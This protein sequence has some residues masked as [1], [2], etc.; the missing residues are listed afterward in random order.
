MA[1]ERE[2]QRKIEAATVT[3]V[4]PGDAAQEKE[5]GY[6]CEPAD[7]PAGRTNGRSNR[8]GSGWFSY[9][10]TVDGNAKSALIV[11]YL[12]EL[13]LLPAAGSF[14]IQIEGVTIAKFESNQTAVGFWEATYPVPAE[15]IRGKAKV[16]VRFQ[17]ATAARIAPV[18]G[19]RIIRADGV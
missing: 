16:T 3:L 4:Q 9:N 1:A 13:G 10:L 19:V 18:F 2:R 14:E 6:V 5:A 7:R 11:T 12:N 8:A 17:A 15:L